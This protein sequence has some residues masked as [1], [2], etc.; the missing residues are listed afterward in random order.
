MAV[1]EQ[2]E[3]KP[4]RLHGQKLKLR[5]KTHTIQFQKAFTSFFPHTLAPTHN[6]DTHNTDMTNAPTNLLSPNL[7]FK[8]QPQYPVPFITLQINTIKI[9]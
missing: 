8:G 7:S 3:T 6:T 9:K 1:T 4:N 2:K 5:D